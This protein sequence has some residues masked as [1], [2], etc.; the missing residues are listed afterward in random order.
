M[1]DAQYPILSSRRNTYDQLL[2]QT[3]VLSLTAQAFLLTIALGSGSSNTARFMSASLSLITAL[4]SILLMA[5]HRYNEIIATKKL[6]EYENEKK[7]DGFDPIHEQR[8]YQTEAALP[9]L[10]WSCYFIWTL[11]L[12]SFAVVA[13]FVLLKPSLLS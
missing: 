3:P 1:D 4:A 5:K 8:P 11:T 2:W 9:W 7:N 13:L 6:T 12:F 10:R